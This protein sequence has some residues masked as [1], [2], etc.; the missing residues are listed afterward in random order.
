MN[1]QASP[2]D[3]WPIL[4][5]IQVPLQAKED[6]H[7]KLYVYLEGV[8]GKF[9]DRLATVRVDFKL[10]HVDAVKL[11]EILK[12]QKY[13]RIEVSLIILWLVHK[14]HSDISQGVEHY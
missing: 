1:D 9:L 2:L 11:P 10:L 6:L 7:G 5:V 4:E 14:L 13:A 8:F 3:G 12:M